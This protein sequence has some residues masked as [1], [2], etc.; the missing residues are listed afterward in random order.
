MIDMII[1]CIRC[2]H[3]KSKVSFYFDKSDD[4]FIGEMMKKKRMNWRK[5][6]HIYTY[7][8]IDYALDIAYGMRISGAVPSRETHAAENINSIIQT[9]CDNM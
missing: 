8:M 1:S 2:F 6:V 4:E 9:M 3:R 5:D 7:Y